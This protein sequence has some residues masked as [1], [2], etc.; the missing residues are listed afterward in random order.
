MRADLHTLLWGVRPETHPLP[1]WT[2]RPTEIPPVGL[3]PRVACALFSRVQNEA[4]PDG[5]VPSRGPLNWALLDHEGRLASGRSWQF[6]FTQEPLAWDSSEPGFGVVRSTDWRVPP[7]PA[8]FL[9]LAF[10]H[11]PS[12]QPTEYRTYCDALLLLTALDGGE[13]I[14]DALIR[15]GAGHRPFD[16]RWDWRGRIHLPPTVWRALDRV[17]RWTERRRSAASAMVALADAV[18]RVHDGS[19]LSA[20]DFAIE[21]VDVEVDQA[22]GDEYAL[23]IQRDGSVRGDDPTSRPGDTLDP[24]QPEGVVVRIGQTSEWASDHAVVP[25]FP[26]VRLGTA[27][28]IM[29]Q[30]AAAFQ[31]ASQ[32]QNGE[33]PELVILPE[34]QIPTPELPT[35]R[36]LVQDTGLA[37][38]AGLYWRALSP[39]Y[40]GLPTTSPPRR[41]FVNEAE[42]VIPLNV[43]QPGPTSVRHFRVRKPVPSHI[44]V[45]LAKELTRR[46]HGG[47]EWQMLRG[48][49]WFRFSHTRWGDFSIAICSDLLDSSPWRAL[50]GRVLHLFM[51]SFNQD[52][53]LFEALT[54]VRAYE[55]YMNVVSVNHGSAGGSFVWTPAR[56]HG[57]ELARLRGQGLVLVADVELHVSALHEAQRHG[58]DQAEKEEAAGWKER[59]DR[60]NAGKPPRKKIGGVDFK[61]PPPG[62]RSRP[63]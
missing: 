45:G 49:R 63:S 10:P 50:Q 9:P 14:L 56:R 40:S 47:A 13:S 17:L 23:T 4:E 43:G 36:Q 59:T 46:R 25:T 48:N 51:V 2:A 60:P 44:E 24:P 11:E 15:R 21:F 52:V 3:P 61:H 35:L 42:L 31:T 29:R 55:G 34:V 8:Y 26:S 62:F 1:E 32:R 12:I 58:V 7:H 57:R 27:S 54:W 41:W 39:V 37:A 20:E 19:G 38:L 6:G 18:R 30:V 5:W 22:L 33:R 28:R 16:E 53:E